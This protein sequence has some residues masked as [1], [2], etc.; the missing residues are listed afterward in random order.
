M[1]KCPNCGSTAQVRFDRVAD[2]FNDDCHI[3][4]YKCG[5]GCVFEAIYELREVNVREE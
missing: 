3:D 5:C 1:I 2:T 4:I